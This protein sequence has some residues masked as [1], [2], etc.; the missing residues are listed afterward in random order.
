MKK[1]SIILVMLLLTACTSEKVVNYNYTI[2]AKTVDMS[3]YDGVNSTNHNFK[4][5]LPNDLFNVIE[6]KSSAVFYLGR[7][8]CSCCQTC[9]KYLN[10]VALE[11][12]VTVYY[13][14][15][16]NPEEPC[17]D[18]EMYEKLF[19]ALYPILDEKDGEKDLYTPHVFSIINGEFDGSLICVGN[20]DWSHHET[21]KQIDGLKDAYYKILKP[22]AD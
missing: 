4:L 17:T 16:Y 20:L 9:V 3:S 21:T 1:I 19:N 15:A 11:L 5:A 22:F 8:D 12:G 10:Q 7:S 18:E 14:D 13:I 2:N 6:T